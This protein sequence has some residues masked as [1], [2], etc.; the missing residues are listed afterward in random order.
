MVES[1][2][3]ELPP[4]EPRALILTGWDLLLLAIDIHC[5]A[6]GCLLSAPFAF[7]PLSL[8]LLSKDG[9]G[10][11]CSPVDIL[12]IIGVFER[13]WIMQIRKLLC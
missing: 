1:I 11:L 10:I 7:K 5:I 3:G 12:G 8:P 4:E 9:L 13:S 2:D 6:L